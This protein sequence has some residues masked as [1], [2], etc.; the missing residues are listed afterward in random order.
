MLGEYVLRIYDQVRG[1]PLY[2]IDR[3]VNVAVPA[4]TQNRKAKPLTSPNDSDA[5]EE[6]LAQTADL[7][8]LAADAM[9]RPAKSQEGTPVG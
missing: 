1:R 8:G 6:L 4:A 2:L 9:A 7:L 3:T 5:I